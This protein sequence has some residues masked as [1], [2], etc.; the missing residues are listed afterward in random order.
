MGDLRHAYKEYNEAKRELRDE[1]LRRDSLVLADTG[2]PI[3]RMNDGYHLR[4][5][6]RV[7]FWP[8]TGTWREFRG[9]AHG[10][11]I[12]SMLKCLGVVVPIPE[13]NLE[14]EPPSQDA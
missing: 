5:A 10:R 4:I 3:I 8:T 2:L 11:G 14:P 6:D 13:L 7:D 1:F 9:G 12:A